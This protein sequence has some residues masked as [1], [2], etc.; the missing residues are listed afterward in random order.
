MFPAAP[1]FTGALRLARLADVP[2]IGVVA[3]FF[4]SSWFG[5]ERPYFNQYPQDTLSSY[6]NSFRNAILDPDSVV[7]VV[8]DTLD[9]AEASHVYDALAAVYPSFEEQIPKESLEKGN[10]IVSVASFSLLP[11]SPRHGQFQPEGEQLLGSFVLFVSLTLLLS[12]ERR[13][14][15]ANQRPRL[16]P[17]QE[18]H[19][20]Q[21]HGRSLTPSGGEVRCLLPHTTAIHFAHN[22]CL[23]LSETGWSLTCW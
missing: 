18:P 3:S 22:D 14:S 23:G 6:R 9:R 16:F 8:E 20:E 5:Y 13:Y 2:R 19:R 21:D 7:V 4:H 17:R 10:A 11:N 15:S 1:P 12:S